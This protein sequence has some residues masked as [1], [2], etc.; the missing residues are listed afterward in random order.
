MLLFWFC[1]PETNNNNKKV[2][3][4]GNMSTDNTTKFKKMQK[5]FIGTS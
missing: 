3:F 4:L 2:T 1:T 5:Q